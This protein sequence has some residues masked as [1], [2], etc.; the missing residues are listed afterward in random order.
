MFDKCIYHASL[1]RTP[2]G[3]PLLHISKGNLSNHCS[4]SMATPNAA[5]CL[6]VSS[7]DTLHA[8]HRR[9][10]N[11]R[12]KG[13]LPTYSRPEMYRLPNPPH[14]LRTSSL[15]KGRYLSKVT[16]NVRS[17]RR[18]ADDESKQVMKQSEDVRHGVR[19]DIQNVLEYLSNLADRAVHIRQRAE[20]VSE[21][22]TKER[23]RIEETSREEVGKNVQ[24]RKEI[25]KE[26]EDRERKV[27]ESRRIRKAQEQQR[28]QARMEYREF[29]RDGRRAGL[30]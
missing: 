21:V 3:T 1:C 15:L 28:H 30:R 8:H 23:E 4:V 12:P 26:R 10:P 29:R 25:A 22:A 6:P 20:K 5:P 17:R 19:E 24:I 18:G 7:T 11:E 13:S 9:R 2:A 14:A 16:Q 27:T